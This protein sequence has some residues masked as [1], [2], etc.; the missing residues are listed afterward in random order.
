MHRRSNHIME[1]AGDLGD[2]HEIGSP[3][4]NR[5]HRIL[6]DTDWVIYYALK[7]AL[8]KSYYKMTTRIGFD[9]GYG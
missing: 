9:Q 1:I 2:L 6:L 7:L 8:V 3:G 5:Y 4:T